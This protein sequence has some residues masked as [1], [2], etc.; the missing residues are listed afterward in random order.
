MLIEN[1]YKVNDI[2]T[3]ALMSGQEALGKFVSEDD[4]VI[5]LQRPLTIAFGQQG[6]TFQP[7]TITGNSEGAVGFR[8]DKVVS[9]LQTNKE[10][11]EAYRAATSGLVVPEKSGL[12]T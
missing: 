5:V 6:A 11:T 12:I 8:L 10:T 1:K 2:I 9:I 4:D 3:I 7:F